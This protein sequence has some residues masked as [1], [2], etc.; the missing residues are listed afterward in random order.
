MAWYIDSE[1]VKKNTVEAA[2][3]KYNKI[4]SIGDNPDHPGIYMCQFCGY[5]DV[6][7]REC[8]SLPPC[9]NCKTP[10]H[11]NKWKLLVRAE[12]AE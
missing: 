6:I 3:S 7:N 1:N 2:K 4:W 9:S 12:N 10:G 11:S 8:Y 5:E